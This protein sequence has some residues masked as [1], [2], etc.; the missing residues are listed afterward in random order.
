MNGGRDKAQAPPKNGS[1]LRDGPRN[2]G[3][4]LTCIFATIGH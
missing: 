4:S 2:A 3:L 1:Q